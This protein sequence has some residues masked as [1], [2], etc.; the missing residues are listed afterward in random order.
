M[1][2]LDRATI[3]K[4]Q[5]EKSGVSSAVHPEDHIFNYVINHSAFNSDVSRVRYY[6][7][8]GKRSSDKFRQ[9][10][11]ARSLNQDKNTVLEFA[12]GYGCVSR[13]LLHASELS[14]ESCD[15]HDEAVSFLQNEIGVRAVKSSPF[16]E[17]LSLPCQYDVVFALS[18]FSHM[19]ITTWARWL[20]ALA[21]ATRTDGLLIFT[22]HGIKSRR[23]FW[24]RPSRKIDSGFKDQVSRPIFRPNNTGPPSSLPISAR[25]T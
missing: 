7:E 19:P 3:I 24:T 18:F 15:I 11:A 23:F 13:H 5:A 12:A 1:V 14:I 9:L 16:P 2:D 10:I 22:T 21:K 25:P 17:M 4:A 8:D 20:V 6:F